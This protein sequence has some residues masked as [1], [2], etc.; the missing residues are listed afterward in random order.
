[1]QAKGWRCEEEVSIVFGTKKARHN[2]VAGFV[3]QEE[4]AYQHMLQAK[5]FERQREQHAFMPPDQ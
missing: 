4:S 2:H 5:I 1:V 3:P